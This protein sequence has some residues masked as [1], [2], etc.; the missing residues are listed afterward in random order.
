MNSNMDS[1]HT[2]GHMINAA[3]NFVESEQIADAE[4]AARVQAAAI[5][6]AII[7]FRADEIAAWADENIGRRIV[8]GRPRK[9]DLVEDVVEFFA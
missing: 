2:V 3:I 5:R 6:S 8:A 7:G 9:A 4:S 1:T